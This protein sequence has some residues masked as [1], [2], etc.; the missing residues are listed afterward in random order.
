MSALTSDSN[1]FLLRDTKKWLSHTSVLWTTVGIMTSTELH[2][3]FISIRD[4]GEGSRVYEY[5]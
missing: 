2:P 4:D 3:R 5:S 1:L